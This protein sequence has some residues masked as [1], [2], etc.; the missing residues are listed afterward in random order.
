MS[1]VILKLDLSP[2]QYPTKVL[3]STLKKSSP[4]SLGRKRSI[5]GVLRY[6]PRQIVVNQLINDYAQV[7]CSVKVC[8]Q[9]SDNKIGRPRVF[10]V[11]M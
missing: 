4:I 2:A 11:F 8:N 3:W 7:L 9:T 6:L 10:F 5:G 1:A